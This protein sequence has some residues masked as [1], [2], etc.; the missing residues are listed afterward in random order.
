MKGKP[1]KKYLRGAVRV[2]VKVR[3]RVVWGAIGAGGDRR[4]THAGIEYC[5]CVCV[6]SCVTVGR[7]FIGCPSEFP[8]VLTAH[9]ATYSR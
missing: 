2:R 6:F 4:C 7:F 1:S 3:V 5:V 8:I 9:A